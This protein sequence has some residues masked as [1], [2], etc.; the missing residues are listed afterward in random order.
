MAL[1]YATRAFGLVSL[2]L[3]TAVVVLGLLVAG[4]RPPQRRPS[5]VRTGLHRSL[6]LL[7]VVF[8]ALHVLTSVADSYVTIRLVDVFVPFGG[9]YRPFW[10]GLG[11]VSFD[12]MLAL[13]VTSLLRAHLRPRIWR[14]IHWLAY[15]CWPIATVHGV[16]AGTDT[17]VTLGL[18]AGCVVAAAIPAGRRLAAARRSTSIRRG[19]SGRALPADGGAPAGGANLVR[20]AG[21]RAVQPLGLD[22]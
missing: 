7:A 18:A 5:A 21:A 4:H 20:P 15:A 12:L 9:S 14:T 3:L 1:W 10:L 8:I 6:A 22:S 2:V 11:A 13:I 16:G 17:T 19:D